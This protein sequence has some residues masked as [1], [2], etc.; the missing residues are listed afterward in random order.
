MTRPTRVLP[1]LLAIVLAACGGRAAMIEHAGQGLSVTL[2]AVNAAR[3]QFMAW[4]E[5]HQ[6][7]IL[8]SNPTREGFDTAIKAYR[9]KQ[10]KVLQAFTVAYGVIGTASAALPLVEADKMS[11]SD[12]VVDL[13]QV[14]DSVKALHAA[15]TDAAGGSP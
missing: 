6:K 11:W 13:L 9:A 14:A 2:N 8:A 3:D 5:A 12:V 7:D 4:D 1:L 15:I 10:A